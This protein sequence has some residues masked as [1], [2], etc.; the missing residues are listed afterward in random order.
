[1]NTYK[2][3][4]LVVALAMCMTASL[5]AVGCNTFRGAGRDISAGGRGIERAADRSRHRDGRREAHGH[6]IAA[7]SERNG[8][9]T[10]SGEVYVRYQSNQSFRISADRG[11]HVTDVMVDGRS[12]G[13][14]TRYT[15]RDVSAN[16]SIDVLFDSNSRR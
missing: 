13:P 5:G 8:S 11:H 7:T 15:F 9:I 2:A 12:I 4:G 10:P 16:H 3:K 6:T 1:M 14:V